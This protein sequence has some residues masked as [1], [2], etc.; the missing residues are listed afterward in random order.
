MIIAEDGQRRSQ[1]SAIGVP[2]YLVST[3]LFEL[4]LIDRMIHK[5][6]VTIETRVAVNRSSIRDSLN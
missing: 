2:A 6:K 4:D 3:I 5:I 1:D